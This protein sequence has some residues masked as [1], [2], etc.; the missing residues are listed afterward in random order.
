MPSSEY[1]AARANAHAANVGRSRTVLPRKHAHGIP[2][3]VVTI[4]R[5]EPG[6]VADVLERGD[7]RLRLA[8]LI[9][10]LTR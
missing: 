10:S 9:A 8:S 7:V 5:A 1:E 2:P 6:E 3:R 4:K